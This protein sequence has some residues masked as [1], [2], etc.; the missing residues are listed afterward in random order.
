MIAIRREW[1]ATYFI[2]IIMQSIPSPPSTALHSAILLQWL[3]HEWTPAAGTTLW[4]L[5]FAAF[6]PHLL[7]MP[8]GME[9]NPTEL[10]FFFHRNKNVKREAK[11]AAEKNVNID[12]TTYNEK[13]I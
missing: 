2:I 5:V 13:N 11:L 1:N 3:M 6:F 7:K 4:D 9:K 12:D 8:R 10:V